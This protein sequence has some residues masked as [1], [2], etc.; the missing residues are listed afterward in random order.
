[1][2]NK[3]PTPKKK[4][5]KL[6]Y[7]RVI[8]AILGIII[9]IIAIVGIVKLI[10]WNR[11]QEFIID[12]NINVDS[13]PEDFVFFM[14]PSRLEGNNYDGNFDILILGNDT[15]AYDKGGTNI[16]ELIEEQTDANV[17][18]C[19]FSGSLM[20]AKSST[21]DEILTVFPA[22]AFCFFWLSDSIQTNNWQLQ[23][24]AIELLSDEYDKEHYI[25]V[26]NELKSIDFNKIDLL[27]IYYDGHDFLE[28]RPM[29]SH[30]SIY[31]ITTIEGGFTGSYERYPINYPYM[32][33][34]LIAPTFCYVI[35]EDGTKE[36]CDI[37]DLGWGNLPTCQ[38]TLQ[39]QAQNYGVSY[40]DNFYGININAETADQYLMSDGITP[41]KEGREMIANRIS[42]C[43]N[44]RITSAY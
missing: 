41:N 31:E 25:Q 22:D 18:N 3:V 8:P 36:G 2:E 13:E 24:D 16:A 35:N 33:H 23:E 14:D 27:L 40:L 42:E 5:I 11:G 20:G 9:I 44:A 19:A 17:Y 7:S 26:L 28:G 10:Q 34:M 15:V 4:K 39:V 21:R 32:Q 30:L 12:E 6:N 29:S 43:I 38:T 37:A 1:M